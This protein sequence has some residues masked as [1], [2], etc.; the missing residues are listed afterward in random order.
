MHRLFL[1]PAALASALA[2]ACG[3]QQLSPTEPRADAPRFNFLNGPPELRNLIR[4]A[5][6]NTGFFILDEES[7]LLAVEGLPANPQDWTGCGGSSDISVLEYQWVGLLH[8][9]IRQLT[10]GRDVGVHIFRLSEIDFNNPQ[11]F[12]VPPIAAGTGRLTLHDND[13]FGTGGKNNAV[14]LEIRGTVTD[15]SSGQLLRVLAHFHVV[16]NLAGFPDVPP[17]IKELKQFVRLN[18]IGGP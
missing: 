2:L 8:N 9:V 13:L 15:L 17:T 5:S 10:V 1:V 16:Q 11:A 18:P 4:F 14:T 12:C 3:D 6:N 7:D